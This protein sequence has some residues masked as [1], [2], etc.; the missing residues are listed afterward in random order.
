MRS[1]V[2]VSILLVDMKFQK[3]ICDKGTLFAKQIIEELCRMVWT[4]LILSMKSSKK[5]N[6]PLAKHEDVFVV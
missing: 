4:K 3:F 5:E 2:V 1:H 6:D